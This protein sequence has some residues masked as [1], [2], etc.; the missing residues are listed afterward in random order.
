MHIFILDG[1]NQ[2][3]YNVRPETKIINIKVAIEKQIKVSPNY[4][5]L[6][7][8]YQQLDDSKSLKDY[9]IKDNSQIVLIVRNKM[10]AFDSR[11]SLI[12]AGYINESKKTNVNSLPIAVAN[13]QSFI[14][15]TNATPV[16]YQKKG[17]CY[18]FAATSAYINTAKRIYGLNINLSFEECYKE[19]YYTKEIDEILG[20]QGGNPKKAIEAIENKYHLGIKCE[21][22][23]SLDIR[24]ALM[25][26]VI[27]SFGTSEE[28]YNCV[29]NG[30][31]L[32]YQP[33]KELGSGHSTLVEGYDF[34]KDCYICK[35]SWVNG[36]N[37]FY[38]TESA[39]HW[40]Q[41]YRV[42]FTEESIRGKKY[43]CLKPNLR[44]FTDKNGIKAAWMDK[45]TAF[46]S[47]KY[48]VIDIRE[49]INGPLKYMGVDVHDYIK[50]VLKRKYEKPDYHYR[51]IELKKRNPPIF[52]TRNNI[53]NNANNDNDVNN[54]KPK[55]IGGVLTLAL[56]WLLLRK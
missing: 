43:P 37:R 13:S 34:K 8:L 24:D 29:G 28:G 32:E 45:N 47:E 48:V 53:N 27:L 22:T 9:S 20:D 14:R 3:Q 41:F 31:L 21:A 39:A 51:N 18:A 56:L 6:M 35:N 10:G 40:F 25:I 54:I 2:I 1:N 19:A 12:T 15:N 23:Q 49:K 38:F 42:Y 46:Y 36:A 5:I 44:T 16:F 4:Q 7:Y 52:S 30:Q 26:S 55:I 50:I 33:G 17:N 11:K